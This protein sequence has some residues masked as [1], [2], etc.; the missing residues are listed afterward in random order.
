MLG[1]QS[2]P[3]WAGCRLVLSSPRVWRPVA[4]SRPSWSSTAG[5]L[6]AGV[7]AAALALPA[8]A[9][10]GER[11]GAPPVFPAEAGRV[12]V[13]V[14]VRDEAGNLIRDLRPEEV[15][16]YE[17]GVRQTVDA[18][19]LVDHAGTGSGAEPGEALF[20]A[21][22]FDRLTPSARSFARRATF[23]ALDG[24]SATRRWIGVFSL[25]RGLSVV[26]P[27]T[28]D[29]ASAREAVGE[30]SLT[31][32]ASEAGL[33]ERQ[34]ARNAYH[35]LGEGFG[36]GHVAPAEDEGAPECRGREDVRTRLFELLESRFAEAF[37]AIERGREDV[38]SRDALRALVEGL[39]P[40]P[41]RKAIVLFSEGLP[42]PSDGLAY[43]R[44]V[45]AAAHRARVSIYAADA[46]GLR[47]A[48]AA[49]EMRRTLDTIQTRAHGDPQGRLVEDGRL[50][51]LERSEEALRRGPA[52]GLLPL[53]EGTGGFLIRGTNDLGRGLEDVLEELGTYHLLSY[54]PRREDDGTFRRISVKVRRPHGRVQARQGYF[55]VKAAL[56]LPDLPHE[57]PALA[58][59]ERDSRPG[60]VPVRLRGLQFPEEAGSSRVSVVVEV[61]AGSLGFEEDASEARFRQ[62]F[63]ILVLVRD[64]SG[65][66]VEKVSQ[67][68]PLTGPLDRLEE[69]RQG[70]VLFYREVR[71]VPGSYA[72]EAV[73]YDA[74]AGRAGV[75]SST[76]EVDDA[77]PGRLRASSLMVVRSAEKLAGEAAGEA[78]PF[79]YHDV[80]L[81]PNMGEPVRRA[82]GRE[83]AFFLTAWPA[84]ERPGVDARVE[85]RRDGRTV[86]AARPVRLRPEAD[87]LIR[88]VSSLPLQALDPGAYELRVTVSDGRDVFTRTTAV[89]IAP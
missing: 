81:Y 36:Q 2:R 85:M 71:L 16:V 50:A 61:P 65:R 49:D 88:L 21:L 41:G 77:R 17:N 1:P 38:T 25:E 4:T 75:A 44:P 55:A 26:E 46:G 54:T 20:L 58:Q 89:P 42:M 24:M 23:A 12:E 87:G 86:A 31:E 8:R 79:R 39:A 62:D 5:A 34:L 69:A 82:P 78:A 32:A 3:P 59:L 67:H 47:V 80:L 27:F 40:L 9:A 6:L 48:S 15:E 43:L 35:G 73:A 72:L 7:L 10:E 76:V 64:A 68:Y 11:T 53:V 22:A 56:P 19:E 52:S 66:V 33:R 70:E 37:H 51:L 84:A 30:I 29:R 45:I 57:A 63:T 14:V 18:F 74:T 28:A 13:D 83:L 60:A